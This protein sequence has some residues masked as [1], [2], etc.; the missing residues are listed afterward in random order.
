MI[1]A[2]SVIKRKH[3]DNFFHILYQLVPPLITQYITK[4]K[5]NNDNKN[6][7]IIY[8]QKYI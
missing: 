2:E 1:L 8:V 5:I 4:S 6:I 7:Y 3:F